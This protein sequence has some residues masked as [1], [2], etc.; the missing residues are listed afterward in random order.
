MLWLLKITKLPPEDTTSGV[1]IHCFPPTVRLVSEVTF[2]A[3]I[4]TPSSDSSIQTSHSP[5]PD[6]DVG[7]SASSME[8]FWCVTSQSKTEPVKMMRDIMITPVW[9]L[10]GSLIGSRE[11]IQERRVLCKDP[12]GSSRVRAS[13][14]VNSRSSAIRQI[15]SCVFAV[16]FTAR[17]AMIIPPIM[18][19]NQ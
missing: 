3:V 18:S 1:S 14:L 7:E 8:I 5:E 17:I 12:R 10:P 2:P 6:A 16:I 19:T 9:F 11:L 15:G 13:L 4:S